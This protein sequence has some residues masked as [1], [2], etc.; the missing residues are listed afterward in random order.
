MQNMKNLMS[1]FSIDAPRLLNSREAELSCNRAFH[2]GTR[3]KAYIFSI[4]SLSSSVG[5]LRI[6]HQLWYTFCHGSA[7]SKS[8]VPLKIYME[9]MKKLV[10]WPRKL[11]YLKGMILHP[12]LYG[13]FHLMSKSYPLKAHQAPTRL[14]RLPHLDRSQMLIRLWNSLYLHIWSLEFHVSPSKV[15]SIHFGLCQCFAFFCQFPFIRHQF[16][17]HGHDR[18][19]HIMDSIW[20]THSI[21]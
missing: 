15:W 20:E 16:H 21:G 9:S 6:E 2:G 13:V 19:E 1:D 3:K 7:V 11:G 14:G 17:P 5:T 8:I 18:I 10:D 4:T 12:I